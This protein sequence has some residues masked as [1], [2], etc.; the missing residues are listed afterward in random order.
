MPR[1]KAA[2]AE[3]IEIPFPAAGDKSLEYSR[4]IP[5]PGPIEPR[6]NTGGV[7]SITGVMESGKSLALIA[8][9]YYLIKFKGYD[10]TRVF[11]NCWIDIP[12]IHHVSNRELKKLLHRAYGKDSP[13]LGQWTGCIFVIMEADS[14]YSHLDSTDKEGS[15]DL[16][17][18]SQSLRFNNY[19]L[20]EYHEGLGVLKFL[21]DKTE[22]GYEP[23]YNRATDHMD[24][25]L[26][27]GHHMNYWLIPIDN[28]SYFHNKYKRFKAIV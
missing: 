14:L 9:I 5:A 10:P 21:R 2:V 22:L 15:H 1:K 11:S 25:V 19:V 8:L 3:L 17:N 24:L 18:L 26:Y 6:Y 12:G 16:W 7:G 4:D 23:F 27:N 20:Y 28:I 13:E